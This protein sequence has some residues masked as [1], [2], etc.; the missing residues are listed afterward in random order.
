MRLQQPQPRS[1]PEGTSGV[2]S[3]AGLRRRS[4]FGEESGNLIGRDGPLAYDAPALQLIGEVDDGGRDVP[5]RSTAVDDD[6]DAALQLVA[7]LLGASA[8]RSTAQDR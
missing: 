4:S 5:G 2:G 7:H 1:S 8:L 6:A 3:G